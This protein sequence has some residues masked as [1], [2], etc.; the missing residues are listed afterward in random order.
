MHKS[1][2]MY[3]KV[4]AMERRMRNRRWSKR[5]PYIAGVSISDYDGMTKE[6][7]TR[8]ISLEGLLVEPSIDEAEEGTMFEIELPVRMSGGKQTHRI[9]VAVVHTSD[10][11]TGFMFM[12]YDRELF[13]LI[14]DITYGN[15]DEHR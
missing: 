10:S 8:N 7:R 2:V 13:G 9:P 15:L 11:G 5:K 14:T 1:Y 12:R 6:C 4:R 3:W